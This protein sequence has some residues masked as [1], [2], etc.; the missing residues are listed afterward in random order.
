MAE[1]DA[2]PSGLAGGDLGWF[3]VG[4]ECAKQIPVTRRRRFR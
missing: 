3:P 1:A 2:L 4:P